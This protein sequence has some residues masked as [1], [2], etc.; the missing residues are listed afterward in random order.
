[1]RAWLAQIARHAALGHRRR[2]RGHGALEEA[3]DLPDQSPTPDEFAA[4]EE[5]AALVRDALTK[6]PEAYREP[7]ILYYCESQSTKAVAEALGITE[8]AARQRL[9]RG[10]ELLRDR[11][12]GLIE[13]VLTRKRPSSIFTMTVAVAI[14]A[15]AAPAAMAGGVF[16]AAST[17]SA[18]T[19]STSFLTTM[20]TSK[21]LLV[22]AAVLTAVCIPLG[23]EWRAGHE[24]PALTRAS[25]QADV[26]SA[27]KQ[28]GTPPSF[29]DSAL[30]AQWKQLHDTYG[31]TA[32]AMPDIYQAIAAL[33]DPF[34]RRAFRA[35][36]IAEW[37]QLDPASGLS[38]FSR[39][40]S[41]AAERRQF[42][43]EWLTHDARGAVEALLAGSLG[44]E[45]MARDSLP[46]I[47]RRVPERVAAIV[48]RLPGSDRPAFWDTKVREAF[49]IVAERG[50]ASARAAAEAIT[51]PNRDLALAGVAQAWAKNDL[52]GAIAWAK[53]QPE[54]TD[55]DEIIRAALAGKAAIDPVSALEN[56]GL[57]PP[58]GNSK[59]FASTTAARVLKE[60]S[61]A[62][63]DAT[64][65][66]LA[67]HPGRFSG[68]DLLGLAHTLTEKLNADPAGFLTRHAQSG[69]LAA[70][71]PAI[72][73]ALLNEGS[74]QRPAV[75]DWLKT[76]PENETTKELRR[77]VLSTGSSQEP[78]LAMRMAAEL[79][80]TADGDSQLREL[81]R[82]L[83]SSER[84]NPFDKLLNQAP[85][86]LRQPLLEAAF[87]YLHADTAGDLRQWI[88]RVP[89]LPEAKRAQGIQSIARAMAEQSP[90]EAMRWS[91]TL[92]EGNIR[93]G[94]V[95]NIASAWAARDPRGASAWVAT[96]PAG[97]E[98]DYSAQL[99]AIAIAEQFPR[100]AWDWAVSIKDESGRM[101]AARHAAHAMA[102]RDSV[103]ARQWI[104]SGP[105]TP[106]AK[107]TLQF[108][109]NAAQSSAT[110]R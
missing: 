11:V 55:R 38:F 83:F 1:L 79:P 34:H 26:K 15:L 67:A 18:A 71:L 44:W 33:K 32:D 47:A 73:S 62:D 91:A 60:A 12:A 21:A 69:S 72:A 42:F 30:F 93:E 104:E 20:S 7:L 85:D 100:E 98:R 19:S 23:Y 45:E 77:Q 3:P 80:R 96:M 82:S 27:A 89:Q 109:L 25:A 76:Q 5:E 13:S 39:R 74:G 63:F 50:L 29:E 56:V 107:A 75:W 4:S 87:E 16:A 103:T 43:D 68:E 84:L 99:L 78:A 59:Y 97:A 48:A 10:R 52:D 46:E 70:M 95:A 53:A 28:P 105:F 2:Q 36:L 102:L 65:N 54:G 90:E 58:G 37:V 35:A 81:A 17:T 57:V 9:A 14:G 110:P 94:A 92:P 61:A 49:A 108:A 40:G 41:D 51:G 66:W 6:L 8:D 24:L 31:T 64:V 88:D 86:R 101:N 106:E 22:A